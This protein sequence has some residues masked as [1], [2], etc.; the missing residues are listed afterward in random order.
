MIKTND[1][2][3]DTFIKAEKGYVANRH[4]NFIFLLNIFFR[5]FLKYFKL[6]DKYREYN[7]HSLFIFNSAVRFINNNNNIIHFKS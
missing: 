2:T 3:F 1:A 7:A 5:K 6:R 4:W